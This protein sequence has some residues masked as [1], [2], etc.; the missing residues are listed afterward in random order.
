MPLRRKLTAWRRSTH[1]ARRSAK[2]LSEQIGAARAER[3]PQ[4][5]FPLARGIAREDQHDQLVREINN[6]S[7]TMAINMR[8]G[9][10]LF[11]VLP[12]PC[13]FLIISSA[14]APFL[15]SVTTPRNKLPQV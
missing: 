14:S 13:E 15:Q 11:D 3:H 8:S 1:R 4:A 7:T 9:F 10:G 2:Q 6:R 5:E 12:L